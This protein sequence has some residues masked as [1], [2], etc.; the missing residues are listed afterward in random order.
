MITKTIEEM[1]KEYIIPKVFVVDMKCEQ[2]LL[3][4]SIDMGTGTEENG[5]TEV[6]K[7]GLFDDIWD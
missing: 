5:V 2:M 4:G 7:Q 3:A 6:R 1:K